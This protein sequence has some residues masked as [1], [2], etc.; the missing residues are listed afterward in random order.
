MPAPTEVLFIGGRSGVGKS[1]VGVEINAQLSAAAV[2][3]C[4]IDGDFLDMAYPVP[5]AHSLAERNLGAMWSNYRA[6]GYRRMIYTNT[7]SVLGD[8]MQGL[9]AAMGDDPKVLAVLLTCTDQAAR[10]RLSQRETDSTLDDHLQRSAD[11]AALLEKDAP[12]WVSRV[13][14]DSRSVADLAT[15]IIGLTGWLDDRVVIRVCTRDDLAAVQTAFESSSFHDE[16]LRT[17]EAG[18]PTYLIAWRDDIPVG[19]LNLKWEGNAQPDVQ[20][21]LP[22][23]PELNA[24]SVRRGALSGASPPADT[25]RTMPRLTNPVVAAGS[26]S[27][28]TQPVLDADGFAMRPWRPEDAPAVVAAYSDP[29]IRQWHARSLDVDEALAWIETW[30]QRWRRET[31]CG[32][33]VANHEGVLGQISLRTVHL[34]EGLA[35]ISYWVMPHAR[36]RRIAPRALAALTQW[37]FNELG[38]HR[39]EILHSTRNP[40]SCRVA[41]RA[42][43]LAEGVK[44][45]EALHADGWHDMHQ[46]ARIATDVPP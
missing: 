11:M 22:G 23:T 31:G 29:N 39:I 9:T 25:L 36:G 8:V 26:L 30:S 10:Q 14:A 21:R 38:L 27:R 43:Y 46:H 40:A 37:A 13:D 12:G 6:L 7:A 18:R 44:R 28:L 19:H 42:G 2:P 16:R 17:Q 20:E 24:V 4:V 33:A 15:R 3:H 32:W 35:D 5:W 41:E 34:D 1:S 45:S